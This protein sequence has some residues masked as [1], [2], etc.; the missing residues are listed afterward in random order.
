M[1]FH[2]KVD[3]AEKQSGIF[4]IL[5]RAKVALGEKIVKRRHDEERENIEHFSEET[6][7]TIIDG[8]MQDIKGQTRGKKT[9]EK[10]LGIYLKKKTPVGKV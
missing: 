9:H 6:A 4:D 3:V 5:R 1:R 7:T 2:S 8:A 10:T